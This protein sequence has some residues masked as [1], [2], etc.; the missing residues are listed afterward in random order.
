MNCLR[1]GSLE[2]A[3]HVDQAKDPQSRRTMIGFLRHLLNRLRSR[4]TVQTVRVS[5]R[6][7]SLL[8]G[9]REYDHFRWDEILEI[10]TFKRDLFIHDDIRLAFRLDHGWLE[11]GEDAQGWS[12]LTE[13]MRRQF[14]E[15]PTDWYTTVM[16][17]PFETCYRLLY[18]RE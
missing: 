4:P 15:I 9:D 14:P 1:L 6:V 13:Q 17:P 12:E 8:I 18:K 11:V 5:N 10:V 2:V 16:F 3:V 7:V